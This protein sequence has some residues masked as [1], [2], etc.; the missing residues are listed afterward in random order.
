MRL[1]MQ[2][3]VTWSLEADCFYCH[4]DPEREAGDDVLCAFGFCEAFAFPCGCNKYFVFTEE[5]LKAYVFATLQESHRFGFPTWRLADLCD[6]TSL[7]RFLDSSVFDKLWLLTMRQKTFKCIWIHWVVG[8][9]L[10]DLGKCEADALI[11]L[12]WA[13]FDYVKLDSVKLYWRKPAKDIQ[14]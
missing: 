2:L 1:L 8:R 9:I 7:R 14:V 12:F 4:G 13:L 10:L 6:I 11:C 3:V 5:D